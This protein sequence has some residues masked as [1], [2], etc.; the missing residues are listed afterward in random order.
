MRLELEPDHVTVVVMLQVCCSH[1]SVIEGRRLHGFVI[2]Q[3]GY[4][5]LEY[6]DF[7]ISGEDVMEVAKCFNKMHGEVRSSIETLTLVILA[8]AKNRKLLQG[9]KLHCFA[10]KSGLYN[11]VLQTSLLDFYAKC[12]DLDKPAQMFREI[13]FKNII[14]WSAMM[15]LSG[16]TEGCG[17]C[18][19]MKWRFGIKHD[20]NHYTCIVDLLA[21]SGKLNEAL[22][23]I[24]KVVAF[25]DGRI[26]GALL[27]ASRAHGN[28]KILEY[29]AQRLLELEPDNAG[30][31]TLLSNVQE[32]VERWNGVEEVRRSMKNNTI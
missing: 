24:L 32:L 6:I 30:Y 9:E 16:L 2:K 23:I 28:P 27:A 15:S 12:G 4:C 26:W 21:R 13:P 1:G 5:L 29:A 11:T 31:Y 10:S 19:S 18:S 7:Y 20:L 25:P 22:A 8:S 3:R 17:V 14:T